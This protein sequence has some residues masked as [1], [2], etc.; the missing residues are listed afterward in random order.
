MAAL[1]HPDISKDDFNLTGPFS[2]EFGLCCIGGSLVGCVLPSDG[3]IELW[4]ELLGRVT[5]NQADLSD[6][7]G[8]LLESQ[9][10][11]KALEAKRP[12]VSDR[13][14]CKPTAE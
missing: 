5:I 14:V 4:G 11:S 10:I 1:L 8:M 12:I 7:R 13:P 9:R 6:G 2:N 3:P